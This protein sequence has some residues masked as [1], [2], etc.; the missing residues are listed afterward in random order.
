MASICIGVRTFC[1][2][3]RNLEQDRRNPSKQQSRDT[4][5]NCRYF[6]FDNGDCV[7]AHRVAETDRGKL[8][9]L[10]M[11][12]R[13]RRDHWIVVAMLLPRV[14]VGTGIDGRPHR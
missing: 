2:D 3:D 6:V 9:R 12:N 10:A 4:N 14:A 1:R 7:D 13:I 11:P 5:S 8:D